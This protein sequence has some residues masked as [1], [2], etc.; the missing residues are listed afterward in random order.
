MAKVLLIDGPM[1]GQVHEWDGV[2]PLLY[3]QPGQPRGIGQYQLV[4]Y[5]LGGRVIRLGTVDRDSLTQRKF[6]EAF[7]AFLASDDALALSLDSAQ[8][9]T[10][11][12]KG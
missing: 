9:Q 11:G 10:A 4:R 6:N 3:D 5:A 8:A 7:W 2:A 12:Q 1:R